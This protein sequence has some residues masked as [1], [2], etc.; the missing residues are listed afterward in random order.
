MQGKPAAGTGGCPCRK[1]RLS[2]LSERWA[3]LQAG[4]LHLFVYCANITST[5][6]GSLCWAMLETGDA[7]VILGSHLKKWG[8]VRF[9]ERDHTV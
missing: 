9:S 4:L 3:L 2:V 8:G 6:V 7:E 5:K 1:D